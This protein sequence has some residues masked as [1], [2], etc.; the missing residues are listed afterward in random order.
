ME[1]FM[2]LGLKKFYDFVI[3]NH[4]THTLAKQSQNRIA[5]LGRM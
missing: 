5:E 2:I 1:S 3:N 4:E